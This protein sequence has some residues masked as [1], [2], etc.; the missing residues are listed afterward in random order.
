MGVTAPA[1]LRDV[2]MRDLADGTFWIKAQD[3]H[4]HFLKRHAG[5][6]DA[7]LMERLLS[8]DR[9][10][11]CSTYATRADAMGVIRIALADGFGDLGERMA[12]T[13]DR[14]VFT[15]AVM[16]DQDAA[17]AEG[18]DAWGRGFVITRGGRLEERVSNAVRL[19]LFRNDAAPYGFTVK[20]AA[21][22]VDAPACSTPT[23]RDVS[24]LVRST[25]AYERL[26]PVRRAFVD[27]AISGPRYDAMY[28]CDR[29]RGESMTLFLPVNGTDEV[30]RVFV[31]ED[32]TS[33]ARYGTDGAEPSPFA[34]LTGSP[35]GARFVPLS[36]DGI[37]GELERLH[38]GSMAEVSAAERAVDAVLGRDSEKD[39]PWYE[40]D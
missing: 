4:S 22:V 26:S 25:M 8:D 3:S 14:N 19:V 16:I 38:P 39:A 30:D 36:G 21:P 24:G 11:A 6:D 34:R 29:R 2:V 17:A 5:L 32:T 31:S 28:R 10:H 20:T 40:Y 35:V 12:T 9:R 23:G 15:L 7:A 13:P 18:V 33:T 1:D 37:T 27:H